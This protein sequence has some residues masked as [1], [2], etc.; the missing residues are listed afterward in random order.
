MSWWNMDSGMRRN[1]SILKNIRR[2]YLQPV[3]S[4]L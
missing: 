1:D 4:S 3:E 2:E